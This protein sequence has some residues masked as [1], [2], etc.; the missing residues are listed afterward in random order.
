[1]SIDP[2]LL[3]GLAKFSNL[4]NQKLPKLKEQDNEYKQTHRES[5]ERIAPEW[6]K[7]IKSILFTEQMIAIKVR[8]MAD[9]ISKGKND[10]LLNH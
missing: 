10:R 5:L 4:L 6:A 8:E 3:E 9:V 7:N 2:E 1:M